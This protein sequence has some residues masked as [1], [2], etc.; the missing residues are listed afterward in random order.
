M[1]YAHGEFIRKARQEYRAIGFILCP[2]FGNQPVYFTR[3]G[4]KHLVFKDGSYRPIN[5]QKRRMN[6]LCKAFYIL[7]SGKSFF[8]MVHLW[9]FAKE[10][11]DKEVIVVV[12]QIDK[13]PKI[14]LSVMDRRV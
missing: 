7:R 10:Y 11:D 14:F 1:D 6:L 12:E 9:S 3:K 5:D 8:S 13:R 2:A 4:F